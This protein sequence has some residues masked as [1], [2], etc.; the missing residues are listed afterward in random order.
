[1]NQTELVWALEQ[2][3]GEARRIA[4]QPGDIGMTE[5]LAQIQQILDQYP[6]SPPATPAGEEV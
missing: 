1:M 6:N 3:T 4:A 2:Q 5:D